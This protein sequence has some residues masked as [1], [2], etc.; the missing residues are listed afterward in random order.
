MFTLPERE[1]PI[2]QLLSGVSSVAAQ[3]LQGFMEKQKR[4]K[5][6]SKITQLLSSL[7]TEDGPLEHAKKIAGADISSEG[8]QSLWKMLEG[9]Y[10]IDSKKKKADKYS[11]DDVATIEKYLGKEVA[12]VFP[13]MTT[14]AQTE[15]FKRALE[16]KARGKST[17]ELFEDQAPL[18]QS[19][20]DKEIV[21]QESPL[22]TDEAT[23]KRFTLP[24]KTVY[25]APKDL[26]DAEKVKWKASTRKENLPIFQDAVAK[27]K[28]HKL[29]VADLN[30]LK[31]INDSDE[32][33]SG[34]GKLIINPE[35][36][37]PY[38][39]AQMVGAVPVA[40]Q[41]WVKTIANFTKYAKDTYGAR[42]TNFD[43]EQFLKRYP[44]L[45]NSSE[46]RRQI[47]DQMMLVSELNTV[48]DKALADVYQK[49]GL[50]NIS[51]EDADA[52][53]QEMIVDEEERITKA[54]REIGNLADMTA[55]KQE[56]EQPKTFD[57]LP[58]PKQYLGRRLRGPNGIIYKSD[59]QRWNEVK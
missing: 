9:A 32:L 6:Q 44:G 8:K 57:E 18:E 2:S 55:A 52:L 49:Y 24:E 30:I 4:Q 38:K 59:G 21:S 20:V 28:A 39:I 5:E 34:L 54:I 16:K 17:K 10:G 42:V 11:T 3:G 51:Y 48:Y 26:T 1:H 46:G 12:E 19:R 53:A 58:N 37:D 15:L 33:P 22:S 47:I 13:L 27:R 50:A 40:V 7:D 41:R 31:D 29:E 45:L 36:G 35:T 25:G 14:G 56:K 43:L 23:K